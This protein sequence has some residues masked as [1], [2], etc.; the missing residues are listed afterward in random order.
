ML[1][2]DYVGSATAS[3]ASGPGIIKS[4]GSG[5]ISGADWATPADCAGTPADTVAGV[6]VGPGGYTQSGGTSV[7]EGDPDIE[8][9]MSD[10]EVLE[11]TGIPWEKLVNGEIVPDYVVADISEWPDL[12][13]QGPD[14]WPLILVTN[15]DLALGN[16]V[17]E[18]LGGQGTIVAVGDL[19]L[20]G[21]PPLGETDPFH[22]DGMVL[23]GGQYTSNGY[24]EIEGALVT[25]LNVLLGADPGEADLGN[26]NKVIKYHSCN[27]AKATT[28]W[29]LPGSLYEEPGTFSER[30]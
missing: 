19:T 22:W 26:G 9:S 6:A 27:V 23:V 11:A 15:T 25:G 21:N 5:I 10:L 4:G 24:S 3:F 30:M 20:N 14:D 1:Y 18:Y 2:S 8:V 13:G 16:T 7:P 17:T 29:N 12:S 28:N